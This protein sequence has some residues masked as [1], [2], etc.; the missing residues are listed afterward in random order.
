MISALKASSESVTKYVI[1][2]FDKTTDIDS[3]VD[4]FEKLMGPYNPLRCENIC[5]YYPDDD[6]AFLYFLSEKRI[7]NRPDFLENYLNDPE[8]HKWIQ[9]EIDKRKR[10][11]TEILKSYGII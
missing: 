4:Y 2:E 5:S 7:S 3:C 1:P 10:E 6:E 8:F 11:N 9:N